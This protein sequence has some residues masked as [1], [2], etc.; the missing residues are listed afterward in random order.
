ML[1]E[2]AD[3]RKTVRR[4]PEAQPRTVLYDVELTLSLPVPLS[5]TSGVNAMAHA[6]EALSS[7]EPNPGTDGH[8]APGRCSGR[9]PSRIPPGTRASAGAWTASGDSCCSPRSCR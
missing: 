5:V 6:V 1:G 8:A 2:T 7:P 4:V 9:R 3:G